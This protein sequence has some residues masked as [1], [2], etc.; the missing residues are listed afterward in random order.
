MDPVDRDLEK[1]EKDASPDRFNT[2]GSKPATK[3]KEESTATGEP[4]ERIPTGHSSSSAPSRSSAARRE[5]GMER[6]TTQHDVPPEL[7][8][9]ETL[10]SR[11]QTQRSQHSLTVAAR[12]RSRKSKKLLP[13][14][15]ADKPYPPALPEREA[16][17]VEFDGVDDPMHA[18]NWPMKAKL[19][20]GAMLAY[21]T[22][23]AAFASSIFSAAIPA[24]AA[25]F[26]V[27]REVGVLGVSF[28]VLG[29]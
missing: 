19:L 13:S 28:Y 8:H 15:G 6:A 22:F 27:G 1:A 26:H 23:T 25:Q 29:E 17:V 4:I 2:P 14:M 20:T 10:M 21:T 3:H 9:N 18:Q 16:Y 5:I 11:I 24:V 12:L 7:E